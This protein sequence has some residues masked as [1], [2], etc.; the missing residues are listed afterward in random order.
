VDGA[1]FIELY[2]PTTAPVSLVGLS[3]ALVNGANS[4]SYNKISLDSV[5]TLPANTYLVI[6]PTA[7]VVTVPS[8]AKTLVFPGTAVTDLIQ[9]GPADAVALVGASGNIVDSLSYEGAATWNTGT[10]TIPLTEGAASTSGL[11]DS[12][13]VAGSLSRLPD[14]VDT[15]VNATDFKFTTTPTPGRPNVP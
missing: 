14:G 15:N 10:T 12:N 1:E 4:L 7:V 9:N 6:G 13:T 8:S 2:N 11:K 3:I 5:G